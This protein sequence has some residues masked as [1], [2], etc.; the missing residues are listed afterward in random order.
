MFFI[1]GGFS[2]LFVM[3]EYELLVKFKVCDGVM[4]N[5]GVGGFLRVVK[6]FFGIN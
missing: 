4:V 3:I 2:D 1:F 6:S 5:F